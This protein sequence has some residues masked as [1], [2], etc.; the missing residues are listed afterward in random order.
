MAWYPIRLSGMVFLCR[1]RA[2][3]LGTVRGQV[4]EEIPVELVIGMFHVS[5][6][7]V[8]SNLVQ[9]CDELAQRLLQILSENAQ[10]KVADITEQYEKIHDKLEKRPETVEELSD[11]RDYMRQ[12][13]KLQQPIEEQIDAMIVEFDTLEDFKFA[14]PDDVFRVRPR[15]ARPSGAALPRRPHIPEP[16][17]ACRRP[18][19]PERPRRRR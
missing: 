7:L 1:R 15:H 16:S 9:K 13:P 14:L 3:R 5:C 4:K 17:N 10:K 2:C 6:E 18:D 8:R 19:R 11:T 12:I